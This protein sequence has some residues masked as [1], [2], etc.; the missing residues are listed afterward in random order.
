MSRKKGA[1]RMSQI[2]IGL[3]PDTLEALRRVA[4][5][6]GAKPAPLARM[7]LVERLRQEIPGWY[8]QAS[9]ETDEPGPSDTPH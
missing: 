5:E 9:R 2:T 7:W 4:Q 3:S 8:P 1:R 6:K